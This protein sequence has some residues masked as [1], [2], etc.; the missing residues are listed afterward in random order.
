MP[1]RGLQVRN[2]GESQV[3]E[4]EFP[5]LNEVHDGHGGNGL[6]TACDAQQRIRLHRDIIFLIHEAI[7]FGQNQLAVVSDR[8][9]GAGH[10]IFAIGRGHK[11]AERCDVRSTG[12]ACLSEHGGKDAQA[13]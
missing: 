9:G 13:P 3:V 5:Q 8:E 10:A 2:Q 11:L 1:S 12:A 4:R 7:S 6:R